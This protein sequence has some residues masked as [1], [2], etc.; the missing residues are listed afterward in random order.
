MTKQLISHI[1]TLLSNDIP[2]K[3]I[4]LYYSFVCFGGYES[5]CLK[6]EVRYSQDSVL[7]LMLF[8]LYIDDL[9]NNTSLSFLNFVGDT[10]LYKIFIILYKYIIIYNII[11][12]WY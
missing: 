7:G 12:I 9:R 4:L 11:V 5:F 10:M 8:V 1:C 6:I 3:K 2:L